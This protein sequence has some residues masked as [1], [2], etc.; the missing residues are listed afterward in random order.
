MKKYI[1]GQIKAF[2]FLFCT[3]CGAKSTE[4]GEC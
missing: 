1:A 4:G 2:G 3:T